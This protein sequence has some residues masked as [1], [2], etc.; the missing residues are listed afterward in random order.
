MGATDNFVDES[1]L[2]ADVQKVLSRMDSRAAHGLSACLPV[3]CDH[4]IIMRS[5]CDV[6]DRCLAA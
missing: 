2:T 6:Q 3:H 1:A 5:S 4:A